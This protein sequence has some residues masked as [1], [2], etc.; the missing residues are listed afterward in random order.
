[1]EIKKLEELL[2]DDNKQV[3]LNPDGTVKIEDAD[4]HDVIVRRLNAK[5]EGLE[6]EIKRNRETIKSFAVWISKCPIAVEIK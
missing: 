3:T 6:L 1:M 2:Q 5:I 4:S